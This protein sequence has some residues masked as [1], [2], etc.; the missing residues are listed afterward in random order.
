MKRNARIVTYILAGLAVGLLVSRLFLYTLSRTQFGM[1]RVRRFAIGWLDDQVE[2]EIH[3]GSF[4]GRG[5]L[6]GLTLKDFYIIDK[7][8][9]PFVAADSA[10]IA[11]NWRTFVTG[12]IVLDRARLFQPKIYLEQLPG[13]S[14]WNY[15]YVFPDRSKPGDPPSQRKLIM[16]NDASVINAD[17]IAKIKAFLLNETHELDWSVKVLEGPECRHVFS[18]NQKGLVRAS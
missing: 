14:I 5:L 4:G 18:V 9:R 10:V 7:K 3:I 12:K 8:G 11:Y 6:G 13:D 2:G 17:L 16:F 15:Q 1:E